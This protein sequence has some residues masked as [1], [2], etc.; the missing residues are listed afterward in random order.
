MGTLTWSQKIREFIGNIGWDLFIFAQWKGNEDAYFDS[1][2]ACE[3]AAGR[4]KQITTHK[5]TL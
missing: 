2:L 3:E 4:I 1:F 5:D